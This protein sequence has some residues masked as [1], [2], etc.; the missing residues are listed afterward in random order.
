[1]DGN[2]MVSSSEM[3]RFQ[4]SQNNNNDHVT[5]CRAFRVN[6]NGRRINI[7]KL[8]EQVGQRLPNIDVWTDTNKQTNK[9]I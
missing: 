8:V 6:L 9:E 2:G 3:P 5:F 7:R 1:M 4:F